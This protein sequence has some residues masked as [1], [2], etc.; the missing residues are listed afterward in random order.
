[1]NEL[2]IEIS[3][4]SQSIQVYAGQGLLSCRKRFSRL[5]YCLIG[6]NILG[7]GAVCVSAYTFP[8]VVPVVLGVGTLGLLA[9]NIHTIATYRRFRNERNRWEPFFTDILKANYGSAFDRIDSIGKKITQ[10][11]T[12]EQF[13]AR[14]L[15]FGYDRFPIEGPFRTDPLYFSRLHSHIAALKAIQEIF[16]R[17]RK[18]AAELESIANQIHLY[19]KFMR[20]RDDEKNVRLVKQLNALDN[21]GAS[22]LHPVKN[23]ASLLLRDFIYAIK[24]IEEGL[25]EDVHYKKRGDPYYRPDGAAP[26]RYLKLILSAEKNNLCD[27]DKD[28]LQKFLRCKNLKEVWDVAQGL[29]QETLDALKER[30][31][32]PQIGH[33]KVEG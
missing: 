23:T 10:G 15:D 32:E 30:I 6:I 19:G 7:I 25:F 29:S 18:D 22:P 3:N 26:L 2:S 14:V 12:P 24:Y 27:E 28:I 21:K 13:N 17:G 1:M 5:D 20:I 33:A 4:L 16:E 8:L 9:Y 31:W 11:K